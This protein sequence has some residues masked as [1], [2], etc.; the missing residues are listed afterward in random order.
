METK[1]CRIYRMVGLGTAEGVPA[2]LIYEP[3]SDEN[4]GN[5]S[6]RW[7]LNVAESTLVGLNEEPQ[8][9]RYL[10]SMYLSPRPCIGFVNEAMF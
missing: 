1:T 10:D 2:W 7:T 4:G 3:A 9:S 6:Y 5:A 8:I